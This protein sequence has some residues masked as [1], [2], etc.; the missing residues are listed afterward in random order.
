M[1]NR[2]VLMFVAG[3]AIFALDAPAAAA[4]ARPTSTRR[5]PVTKESPGEVTVRVD[6][7]TVFKTDTLQMPGRTDT[8]VKTNTVTRVDTVT[9]IP[10]IRHIGGLYFG[11]AGGSSL[12]AADFNNSDHP[13]WN[14]EGLLGV[15]P[16][17]SWL[18][19]RAR[20]GYSHYSPH[21]FAEP[22]LDDAK[23]FT[24]G[25]DL[26][27]RAVTLTPFNKRV[28][29]YGIGGASWNRFKNILENDNGVLTI[30]DVGTVNGQFTT[31]DDDWHS[32]WGWDAGAGAEMGWGRT[33]LFIE[34]RFTRFKGVNTNISHVPLIIG[35]SWY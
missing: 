1:F 26:K 16:V 29:V 9:V 20:V 21:D 3:A 32:G 25:G 18:G 15:D 7:L 33:N 2:N 8:V 11:V 5:I 30:G 17:G 23:I 24:V 31:V 10:K 4:Q 19:A 35:L 22:F 14:V 27:L 6:T 12:P 34:S 13:G 28:Q